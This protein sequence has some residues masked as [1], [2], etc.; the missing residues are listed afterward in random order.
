MFLV[1]YCDRSGRFLYTNAG[2]NPPVLRQSS[3]GKVRFL[4]PIGP[5]LGLVPS[6]EYKTDEVFAESGG[7]VTALYRRTC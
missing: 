2:H 4:N 6:T 3:N 5:T 1:Y 7:S